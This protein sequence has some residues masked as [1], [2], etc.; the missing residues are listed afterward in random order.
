MDSLICYEEERGGRW[1]RQLKT[2]PPL[3]NNPKAKQPQ[4]REVLSV[5]PLPLS[6]SVSLPKRF[7]RKFVAEDLRDLLQRCEIRG[8]LNPAT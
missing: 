4:T 8:Q 5:V 1:D 7:A 6:S 2:T 3:E